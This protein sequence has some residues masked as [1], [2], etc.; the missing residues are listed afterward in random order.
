[1]YAEP[2]HAW[3]WQSGLIEFGREVPEGAIS[4]ATG[5]DV[6]LRQRVDAVARH[7]QGKIE[8]KLLV[9]GVPEAETE[10]A[11][12]ETLYAWVNWCANANGKKGSNG[13]V[14]AYTLPA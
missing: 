13:V 6:P 1:M 9:P 14:F 5:M 11:K 4:F 8:G 12:V 3:A 10:K 7:G 2:V